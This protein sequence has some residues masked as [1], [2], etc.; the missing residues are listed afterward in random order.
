M[1]TAG[2]FFAYLCLAS[3]IVSLVWVAF[4]SAAIW[5]GAIDARLFMWRR[6]IKLCR[7]I[8]R[9]YGKTWR[10]SWTD[11]GLICRNTV[12]ILREMHDEA[13]A[14]ARERDAFRASVELDLGRLPVTGEVA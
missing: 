1:D 12:L 8:R 13:A 4:F 11:A 5:W 7:R 2:L 14:E 10:H 3:L 6:Q 9:D